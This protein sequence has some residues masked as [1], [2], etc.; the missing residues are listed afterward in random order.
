MQFINNHYLVCKDKVC[1]CACVYL[2]H[3]CIAVMIVL[4]HHSLNSGK[5]VGD[6]VLVLVTYGLK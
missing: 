5:S 3:V 2:E 1:S 6:T 4:Y